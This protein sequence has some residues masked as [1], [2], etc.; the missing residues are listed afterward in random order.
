MKHF[1]RIKVLDN[2][3]V[4]ATAA[5]ES[6]WLD[7]RHMEKLRGLTLSATSV[8]GAANVKLEYQVSEDKM[9]ATDYS[10]AQALTSS[11]AT[12]F[13]TAPEGMHSLDMPDV[14][15]RYV[16]FRVTGVGSNPADTRVTAILAFE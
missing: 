10:E 9:S 14:N 11:T 13:T 2:V 16:R 15:A 3:L 6:G 7:T 5:V 12:D 4:N 8:L 1:G